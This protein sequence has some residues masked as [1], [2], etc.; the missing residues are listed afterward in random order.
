MLV[1]PEDPGEPYVA[2]VDGVERMW[3]IIPTGSPDPELRVRRHPVF[4]HQTQVAAC[5]FGKMI[6]TTT[7]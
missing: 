6:G 2:V 7:F 5:Q 3:L 1:D 4:T